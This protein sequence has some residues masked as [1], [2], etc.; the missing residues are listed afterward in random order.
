ML[1]HDTFLFV[2]V[3]WLSQHLPTYVW[4]LAVIHNR[5]IES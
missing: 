4:L 3:G 5:I 2:A 1:L